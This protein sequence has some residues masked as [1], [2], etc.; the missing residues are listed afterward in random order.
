MSLQGKTIFLTGG[1]RGI[2]RAIALRCAREGANIAIAAKT[3]DPHPTLL[4]T[5]YLVAAEVEE[6][7]GRALPLL[8]DVRND[9]RIDEAVGETV[10][11]FGGLDA[12]INN[13]GAISLT[14][15]TATPMKRVDLMIGINVRAAY[16]CS[17]AAIP[18][19]KKGENSHI[20]N[21]SPPI[22]LDPRWLKN[23]VAYTISKYGM[24]MCTIGM[25]AELAG[26][27]IAVNS[28][29]PR[30]VIDTAALRLVGGM[31]LAKNG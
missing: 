27:G 14:P 2:G 20:I 8:V 5:I 29:W 6:A 19:L 26:A 4:G 11:H 17:R 25:S 21:M 3:S 22:D 13:A 18:F 9:A 30:T 12:V 7:G 23:H 15:T 16:A 24:S 10:N 1:S 31:A 28:L